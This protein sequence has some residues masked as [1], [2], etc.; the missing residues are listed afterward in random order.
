MEQIF[1]F[2]KDYWVIIVVVLLAVTL[3]NML[4]NTLLKLALYAVVIGAILVVGFHYEPKEVIDLGKN[5]TAA[6]VQHFHKTIEP[7]LDAELSEA[8]TTFHPDG[9]YELKTKSLRIAGKKGSDEA[10]VYVKNQT[11]HVKL[12]DLGEKVQTLLA[13]QQRNS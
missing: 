7:I 6:A 13:Q 2:I 3:L 9:T 1:S 10:T 11:F 12:S 5:A 8:K 4:F